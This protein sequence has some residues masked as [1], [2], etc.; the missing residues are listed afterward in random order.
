MPE[1]SNGK[2]DCAR[3]MSVLG[4]QHVQTPAYQYALN[5]R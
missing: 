4:T 1:M 5:S 3:D 2:L